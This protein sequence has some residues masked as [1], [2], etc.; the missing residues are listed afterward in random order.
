MKPLIY[1]AG[2]YASDPIGNTSKAIMVAEMILVAGGTPLIPHLNHYWHEQVPHTREEWMEMDLNMLNH[3]D[4]MYRMSGESPGADEE[5]T[6]ANNN[7]IPVFHSL[8][9]VKKY[10]FD[11]D[12]VQW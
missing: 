8:S 5:E 6:F 11:F 12:S 9:E 10:C 3:C 1:I 2:P 4:A 7:H